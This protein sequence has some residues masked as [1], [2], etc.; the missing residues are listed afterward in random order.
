MLMFA[1]AADEE[2]FEDLPEE[3]K[4]AIWTY[5]DFIETIPIGEPLPR[6]PC[7]WLDVERKRCRWYE[8]R[9]SV[10]REFEVGGEGCLEWRTHYWHTTLT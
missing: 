1:T 10:C 4:E 9:P 6:Q 7:C 8:F 5:L 2:R 3:A